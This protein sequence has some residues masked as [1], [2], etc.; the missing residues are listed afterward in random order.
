MKYTL[1]RAF[2]SEPATT[3]FGFPSPIY[4][5][6]VSSDGEHFAILSDN[7]GAAAREIRVIQNFSE[8]LK[9]LVPN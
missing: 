5:Y 8:E 6:D 9:R 4:D 7:P 2:N 1:D 3:V